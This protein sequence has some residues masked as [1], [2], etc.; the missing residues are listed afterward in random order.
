MKS[1]K[2]TIAAVVIG[3]IVPIPWLSVAGA[4]PLNQKEIGAAML[5]KPLLT[6]RFGLQIQMVYRS[7]GAVTAKT[8]L[9]TSSGTWRY[10]GNQV[11]TTFP[12][13]PAKGTSCATF[14]RIGDNQYRSSKGVKFRV[15]G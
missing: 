10:K 13:G 1:L 7:N 12:S 9:G 14:T 11:C 4:A 5:N 3:T 15:G 2:I 6:R 8:V